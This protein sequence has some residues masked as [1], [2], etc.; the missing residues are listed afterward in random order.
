MKIFLYILISFNFL[1]SSNESDWNIL[2]EEPVLIKVMETHY[3]HCQAEII[4]H[5][6][7]D[8]ILKV[9]EDV[10]SYKL[11]FDS[12]VISDM[13]ANGEVRLGI[14]MP[15]PFSDRDYT[16][17]FNRLEGDNIIS[18]LYNPIVSENF[19]LD[20]NYIRLTEAR[21]GWILTK[22]KDNKTLVTYKWNGDMRGDFPKWAYS[23]AWVKQGN[24]IMLNLKNEVKRRNKSND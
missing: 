14:D 7:I 11:F 16:V 5:E 15:F 22:I 17:K 21:G 4:I 1:I 23:R 12:I 2:S 8:N 6:T 9:I 13:N 3:P 19:P 24:E 10:N 20:D 18:Y